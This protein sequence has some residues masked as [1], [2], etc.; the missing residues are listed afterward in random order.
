MKYNNLNYL[1]AMDGNQRQV[2]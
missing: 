1:V 2:N